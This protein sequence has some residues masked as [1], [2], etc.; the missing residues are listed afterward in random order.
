MT[1]RAWEIAGDA[2]SLW[3]TTINCIRGTTWGALAVSKGNFGGHR[4]G[5]WWNGQAQGKVEAEKIAYIKL[6]ETFHLLG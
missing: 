1:M 2:N 5:W 3:T 4:G 6:V